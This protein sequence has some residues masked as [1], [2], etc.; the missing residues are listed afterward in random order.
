VVNREVTDQGLGALNIERRFSNF[1]V[2]GSIL[3]HSRK[4]WLGIAGVG[5]WG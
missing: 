4:M 2:E 3:G 1:L 5:V